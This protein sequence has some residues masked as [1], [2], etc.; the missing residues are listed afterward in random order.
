MSSDEPREV[1]LATQQLIAAAFDDVAAR[2]PD[3]LDAS[4]VL[5][6]R[7]GNSIALW[8][9]SDGWHALLRRA[10]ADV[11]GARGMASIVVDAHGRL[12]WNRHPSTSDA[13]GLFI[14]VLVTAVLVLDR[15]IG[16]ELTEALVAQALVRDGSDHEEGAQ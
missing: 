6:S 16:S 9:G 5:C 10:V 7:L 11:A 1:A 15:F 14:E 8:V 3:L 13:R 2:V 4:N 12:E